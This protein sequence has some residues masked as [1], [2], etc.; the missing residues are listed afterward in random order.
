MKV[1]VIGA[2][3]SGLCAAYRLQK[4]HEVHLFEK[5]DRLGGNIS[6]LNGNIASSAMREPVKIEAGVLGF[7]QAS[8]P[9]VHR[10][11]DE[12]GVAQTTKTPTS[13]LFM[14]DVFL[15]SDPQKLLATSALPRL[16]TQP[17]QMRHLMQ[18]RRHYRDTFRNVVRREGLAD[19]Q[20]H[21]LLRDN[22]S[23]ALKSFI[24]SLASLAFSTS[25]EGAGALPASMVGPYLNATRYPEWTALKGGVWS[26]VEK[27]LEKSKFRIS[28]GIQNIRVSRSANSVTVRAHGE[29]L[30]FDEVVIAATPGQ[31]LNILDDPNNEERHVFSAWS[32]HSFRTRA[33]TSDKVYGRMRRLPRTPMDLFVDGVGRGFGYNT[34]MNEFYDI[35]GRT[36][37]SFSYNLDDRIPEEAILHTENH[38]VPTYTVDSTSTVDR[39]WEMN[40]RNST[41]FCGA[42]LGDGL[43]EGAIA[44]AE[45]VASSL[46]CG[47]RDRISASLIAE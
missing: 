28:T 31:V 24:H 15:P 9:S 10:L 1:A 5:R 44:S 36:P 33:H 43:H 41:W 27:L 2:G 20:I 4:D 7:H 6:T 12:L 22:E 17:G 45:K 21:D 26:Y 47:E 35:P 37:Y 34:Y 30:A 23:P 11:F 3:A 38:T 42:Y 18:M 14:G 8:Y 16:I 29:A 19:E 46:Q 25:E 39:I 13:A 40:G 32:D